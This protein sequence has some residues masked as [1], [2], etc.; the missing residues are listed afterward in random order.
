[1]I[2]L[3]RLEVAFFVLGA[4]LLALW[5]AA[6]IDRAAFQWSAG[7]RLDAALAE[8]LPWRGPACETLASARAARREA[9]RT[10]LIGRLEIPRLRLSAIVAEGTSGTTLRRAIGHVRGTAFPG[11]KGNVALAGHRD[12]FFRRLGRLHAHDLIRV[13]TPDGRFLYRVEWTRI[14]RPDRVGLI[15]RTRGP[16]ITLVTCYPFAWLGPAP[17]R[18]V[19]RARLVA[20]RPARAP[21]PNRVSA[22]S[23]DSRPTWR[24]PWRPREFATSTNMA[25]SSM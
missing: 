22:R 1:M 17:E 13:V 5:G 10:G 21:S 3:R 15:G 25:R 11:E 12:G 16:A 8:I 6:R 4:F 2:A 20:A 9:R 18:F 19:V 24:M 7:R 23:V 14:V